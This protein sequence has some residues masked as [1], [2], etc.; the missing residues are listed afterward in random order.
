MLLLSLIGQEGAFKLLR[1]THVAAQ[2][3]PGQNVT[4]PARAR[5]YLERYFSKLR[6]PAIDI[7]WGSVDEFALEL[8]QVWAGDR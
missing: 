5:R 7:Y 6:Q 4:S 8:A 3:A 1:Y 2:V